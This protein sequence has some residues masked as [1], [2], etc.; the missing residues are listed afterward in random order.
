M[1]AT[2]KIDVAFQDRIGVGWSQHYQHLKKQLKC[3]SER[4]LEKTGPLPQILDN[5]TTAHLPIA[6]P[7][8]VSHS[9]IGKTMVL[10][11]LPMM[12]TLKI[13]LAFQN[14]IGVD[15]ISIWNTSFRTF[16]LKKSNLFLAYLLNYSSQS[17]VIKFCLTCLQLTST[18]FKPTLLV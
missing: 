5:K 14:W 12:A 2:L 4:L 15:W 13:D 17:D 10:P 9:S 18:K 1:T 6:L 16:L 3:H 8:P 11:V 7:R